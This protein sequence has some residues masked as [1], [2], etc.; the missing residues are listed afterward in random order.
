MQKEQ[1]EA[2]VRALLKHESA[3]KKGK[4][5]GL[6]DESDDKVMSLVVGMKDFPKKQR[7]KPYPI[8]IPN[9]LHSASDICLIV[10]DPQKALKD[11]LD[12]EPIDGIVKVIGLQKLR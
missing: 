7:T 6:F 10:K 1:V 8:G 2:A 11:R 5:S 3:P 12:A 4:K 9:S